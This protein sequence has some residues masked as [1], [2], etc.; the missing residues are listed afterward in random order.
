M[1]YTWQLVDTLEHFKVIDHN[2]ENH[3][4]RREKSFYY[5]LTPVVLECRGS[6][7]LSKFDLSW[8]FCFVCSLAGFCGT[9]F[10]LRGTSP[11][12]SNC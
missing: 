3:N 9:W 11:F 10:S 2:L 8:Y 12:G 7:L 5:R 4:G 6:F 1:K